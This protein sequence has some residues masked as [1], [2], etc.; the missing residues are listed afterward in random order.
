MPIEKEFILDK[1]F[2]DMSTLKSFE[3][4]IQ[5]KINIRLRKQ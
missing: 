2:N 3:V 1:F 4:N 5:L